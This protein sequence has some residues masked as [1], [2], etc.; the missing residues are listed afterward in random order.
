MNDRTICLALVAAVGIGTVSLP[1]AA[2]AQPLPFGP[3]TCK[4]GFV[5][6]EAFHGDFVCVTPG[7]RSEAAADN[8]AARSRIQPGGGASGPLTCR[9]GFV[10]REARPSD[11]VCVTPSVRART[12]QENLDAVSRFALYS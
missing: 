2:V 4:S 6:R 12:R 5:W 1:S 11:R 3:T 7:S 8:A 10:W 9:P